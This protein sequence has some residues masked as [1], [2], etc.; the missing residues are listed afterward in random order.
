M[1]A[2]ALNKWFS[3]LLQVI[4]HNAWNFWFQWKEKK[5]R[6]DLIINLPVGVDNVY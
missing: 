3:D 4:Y 1:S 2:Y 6:V 5:V